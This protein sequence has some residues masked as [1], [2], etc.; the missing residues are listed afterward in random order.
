[1]KLK[2]WRYNMRTAFNNEGRR[3]EYRTMMKARSDRVVI[4]S[5]CEIREIRE[6]RRH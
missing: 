4:I 5:K 6:K 3:E 2:F 1:M